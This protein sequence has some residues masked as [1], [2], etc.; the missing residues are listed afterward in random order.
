LTE[1]LDFPKYL[2]GPGFL[3]RCAVV[4]TLFDL[5]KETPDGLLFIP[6]SIFDY[7]TV[8]TII[9]NYN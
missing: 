1:N 4:S 8:N 7:E 3:K 9:N 6:F 5:A 2:L